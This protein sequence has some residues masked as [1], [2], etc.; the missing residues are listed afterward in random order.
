MRATGRI[1]A[2]AGE[3]RGP[4]FGLE[5]LSRLQLWAVSL[6]LF[7]ACLVSY[8]PWRQPAALQSVPILGE[9]IRV[10]DNLYR[11]G[12]FAN[13]FGTLPTGYTGLVPPGYSGFVTYLFHVLGE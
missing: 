13:P 10:A 9:P 5:P 8:H 7:A 3:R 11:S 1:G 6:I 2:Q 12:A 4:D